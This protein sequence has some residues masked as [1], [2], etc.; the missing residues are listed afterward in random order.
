MLEVITGNPPFDGSEPC[1][2]GQ[3]RY[4][5]DDQM[6]NQQDLLPGMAVSRENTTSNANRKNIWK[7]G[8]SHARPE[9]LGVVFTKGTAPQLTVKQ[10]VTNADVCSVLYK[11]YCPVL[12]APG[13]VVRPGQWLEPIPA[14]ASQALFRV[15]AAGKGVAQ[16][17]DY[18]DNSAGTAGVWVGCDLG[19]A[20]AGGLI[21][22]VGPSA[23]LTGVTIETAYGLPAV[24]T[25]T[26]PANSLRVGDRLRVVASVLSNNMAAGANTAKVRIN[27]IAGALLATA[28]AVTFAA[29]DVVDFVSDLYVSAIGGSGNLSQSGIIS[30]GTPGTATARAIPGQVA[31][32]TTVDNVL[33]VTNTPNNV[34][35]SSTLLFLSVEKLAS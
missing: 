10:S 1:P 8:D 31:I 27:G 26:I 4:G 3:G 7:Y 25:V 21:G 28:P 17:R 24:A 20:P 11:G 13:Q 19:C 2:T 16:S 29:A 14:G 15:A 12:L 33:T 23:A 34:A 35:D 9:F 32:D 30:A 18:M 6:R 5:V 22:A